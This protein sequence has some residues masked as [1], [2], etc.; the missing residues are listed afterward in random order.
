M[1]V[2]FLSC[3]WKESNILFRL[4]QNLYVPL[5]SMFLFI[6]FLFSDVFVEFIVVVKKL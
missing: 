1:I 4:I 6:C 2:S 3:R 5:I